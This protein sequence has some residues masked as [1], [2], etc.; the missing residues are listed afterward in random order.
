[1]KNTWPNKTTQGLPCC[2]KPGHSLL[3]PEWRSPRAWSSGSPST[4]WWTPCPARAPGPPLD[5]REAEPDE[6]SWC[7][8]WR[9]GSRCWT[10]G[11]SATPGGVRRALVRL[12]PETLNL[13]H[14]LTGARPDS[15]LELLSPSLFFPKQGFFAGIRKRRKPRK[16]ETVASVR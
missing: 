9:Q 13:D 1:M 10:R 11:Y 5:D 7:D 15:S 8:S 16:T 6:P 4:W 12:L 3:P 14:Y 2:Q